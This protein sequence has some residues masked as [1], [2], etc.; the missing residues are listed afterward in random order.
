[1]RPWWAGALLCAAGAAVA[2]SAAPAHVLV[3]VDGASNWTSLSARLPAPDALL[4]MTPLTVGD[5]A[6]SPESA[7]TSSA[8]STGCIGARRAV[9]ALGV[10]LGD[11]ARTAGLATAAV[12][13]ACLTD[14]T[15]A[16]FFGRS[17]DRYDAAG[18]AASIRTAGIGIAL[19]GA[20][21]LFIP[22]NAS[23]DVCFPTTRAQLGAAVRG[24]PANRTI[25]AG[26]GDMRSALAAECLHMPFANTLGTSLPTLT[27]MTAAV[28]ARTSASVPATGVFIV[29]AQDRMDHAVHAGNQV[30]MM[31]TDGDTL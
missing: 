12:T 6:A 28:M 9:A 23:G 8:M 10:P 22:A 16:A 29:V 21:R 20:S 24:C 3:I 18:L 30:R 25:T 17:P 2:A 31:P 5:T 13:N 14:P 7:S 4:Y 1:M 15:A 11:R 27:D 19:M 26:F